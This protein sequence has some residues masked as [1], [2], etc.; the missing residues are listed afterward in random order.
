MSDI[1]QKF[2]KKHQEAFDELNAK[3]N[4]SNDEITTWFKQ[5]QEII[6][7]NETCAGLSSN[8]CFNPHFLH[9]A[10]KRNETGQI[11]LT[12]V[13]CPKK[14]YASAYLINDG[15]DIKA[16][17]LN[18]T[19]E[20]FKRIAIYLNIPNIEH[21]IWLSGQPGVCKSYALKYLTDKWANGNKKVAFVS[22]TSFVLSLKEAIDLKKEGQESFKDKLYK[23]AFK[24]AD[25]LILDDIG[26]EAPSKWFYEQLLDLLNFRMENHLITFFSSNY[27]MNE[28]FEQKLLKVLTIT[29]A[30]RLVERVKTL[31]NNEQ[32]VCSET[33][34]HRYGTIAGEFDCCDFVQELKKWLL[35]AHSKELNSLN[36][37]FKAKTKNIV[38]AQIIFFIVNALH[39]KGFFAYKQFN[40][41]YQLLTN[42]KHGISKSTVY[43][44]VRKLKQKGIID[45][46]PAKQVLKD[47]ERKKISRATRKAIG[48]NPFKWIFIF[49]AK[50]IKIYELFK[51]L[52]HKQIRHLEIHYEMCLASDFVNFTPWPFGVVPHS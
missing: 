9:L 47:N 22:T 20:C 10:L 14:Q 45:H 18:N 28:W 7:Q 27:T 24:E 25:L 38:V 4:L 32:F 13:N 46:K 30:K 6:I 31:T 49:L 52:W 23:K 29:D 21:G 15:Q 43:K 39:K 33:K 1:N 48:C 19:Y 3:V 34:S 2:I 44:T 35:K 51:T 41:V 36:A 11:E 17:A 26:A 8:K 5:I 16:I 42:D 37:C 50:N 12:V 40:I